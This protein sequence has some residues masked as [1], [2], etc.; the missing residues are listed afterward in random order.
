MS[1]VSS[2][3]EAQA[4]LSITVRAVDS[5]YFKKCDTLSQQRFLDEAISK[6]HEVQS[7]VKKA[8]GQS[9]DS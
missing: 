2:Y 3:M 6:L 1:N 4:L 5:L 8:K 7:L 9:H